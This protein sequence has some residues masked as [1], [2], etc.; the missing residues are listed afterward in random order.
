MKRSFAIAYAVMVVVSLAPCGASAQ[1]KFAVE[2]E[3]GRNF[4]LTSY[5]RNVVYSEAEVEGDDFAGTEPFRPVLVDEKSGWGTAFALRFVGN[6]IMGGLTVRWFN[7]E[8]ARVHHRGS[9]PNSRDNRLRSSRIRTNGTIDDSGVNYTPVEQE[10][11]VPVGPLKSANLFVFGLE[12]GY[13]FYVYQGDFDIFIPASGSIILTRLGR[14][15]APFRPG[16]GVYTGASASFDFVS[17]MSLVLGGRIHGFATPTYWNRSDAARR[18]SE[19]GQ[20][21]ESAL[22]S[23]QLFFSLDLGVQFAIR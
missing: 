16:L 11:D 3:G 8:E 10:E 14:R 22:F 23:S 13:R 7:V 17:V 6:G 18:A 21:T 15:F 1:P 19:L 9:I 20:T 12:G 4:G 2:V 5:L